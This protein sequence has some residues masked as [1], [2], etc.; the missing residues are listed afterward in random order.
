MIGTHENS[1]RFMFYFTFIADGKRHKRFGSKPS[2]EA[3]RKAPVKVI[4]MNVRGEIVRRYLN[5]L[6]D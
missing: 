1:F 6:N 2:S 4:T 5:Y 3:W